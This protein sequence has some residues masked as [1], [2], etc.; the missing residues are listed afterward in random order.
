MYTQLISFVSWIL[1][2]NYFIIRH[3][4]DV[5]NANNLTSLTHCSLSTLIFLF[6]SYYNTSNLEVL[7]I[8]YNLSSSYFASDMIKLLFI[9]KYRLDTYIY[10][11]HHILSIYMLGFL[12]NEDY[13]L[14]VSKIVFWGELSNIPSFFV[15][16]ILHNNDS[17]ISKYLPMIKNIQVLLYG[18]IR[19]F[20][21]GYLALNNPFKN[22]EKIFLYNAYIMYFIGFF[23]SLILFKKNNYMP[24]RRI[25]F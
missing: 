3:K 23:W 14:W 25:F 11:F 9:P 4:K 8:G 10:F 17:I 18:Y 19:I 24:I 16:H 13:R 22:N 20:V 5:N 7:D 12:K 6:T 2:F 1:Y 15:Y 21:I